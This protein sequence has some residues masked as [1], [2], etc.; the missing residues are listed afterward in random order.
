VIELDATDTAILTAL[1][2]DGRM[3]NIELAELVSLS[4]SACLRRVRRLEQGGVID[5]Y[6]ALVNNEAVAR[7][8]SVFV[9]ISLSS[10]R[11][12][13]LDR[14]EEA[15]RSTPEVMECHLMAGNADYLVKVQCSDVA[16]YERIHRQYL[17]VLPGVTRLR[18]SFALRTVLS[19]TALDID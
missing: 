10:Q 12:E 18:T 5:R 4:P 2:S 3:T 19:T 1:Q 16:D 14:F 11:E 9:E 15:I 6:V 8:T 17:A 7:P 13:D